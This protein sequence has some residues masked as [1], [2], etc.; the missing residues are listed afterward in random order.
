MQEFFKGGCQYLLTELDWKI[1]MN[2]TQTKDIIAGLQK[3][4][5]SLEDSMA[6]MVGMK[7]HRCID[8][9]SQ[10]QLYEIAGRLYYVCTISLRP[11]SN[12]YKVYGSQ[13]TCLFVYTLK[14]RKAL[15][16]NVSAIDKQPN[17]KVKALLNN[18]DGEKV[19]R[20]FNDG[21]PAKDIIEITVLP[22]GEECNTFPSKEMREPKVLEIPFEAEGDGKDIGWMYGFLC[23]LKE[24]QVGL[25]PDE[26]A[27]YL[28]YKLVI[29]YDNLTEAERSSIFNTDGKLA[30]QEV[31]RHYLLWKEEAHKLTEKDAETLSKLK[32]IRFYERFY[33]A[34]KALSD[35]GLSM[36]KLLKKYP[37]KAQ[38]LLRHIFTFNEKNYNSTGR[39]PLYMNFESFLHIYLRHVKELT[40]ENQFSE[41]DKFQ[42]KEKDVFI[43]MDIVM[44]KLND[45]YQQYKL[46]HPDGRF[47]RN[48]RM[49]YYHNGDYY[50][51]DVAPNG[52]ISTF[53]RYYGNK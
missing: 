30:N 18:L 34:D 12:S 52:C 40:I 14:E 42:L 32:R 46:E 27:Q 9:F 20:L 13:L 21:I 26:E 2:A 43:V 51:I 31:A 29:E 48:G 53:Y 33:A 7:V 16:E 50:C 19:D 37:E 39:F 23:R 10:S 1:N 45:K 47:F 22:Y 49:A 25:S 41:R 6:E 17:V 44:E 35:M 11:D 4:L 3:Q 36:K 8:G 15:E 28:A 24:R 5:E 38:L